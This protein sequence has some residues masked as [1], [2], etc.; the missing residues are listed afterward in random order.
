VYYVSDK[1]SSL[2][3]GI[4]ACYI[5]PSIDCK[6]ALHIKGTRL[7]SPITKPNYNKFIYILA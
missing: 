3:T 1:I 6:I 5:D 4:F 2:C 7:S